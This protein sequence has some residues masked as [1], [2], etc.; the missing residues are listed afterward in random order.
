LPERNGAY[1]IEIK[2][3]GGELLRTINGNT[4]NS[5]IK[6]HWDLTDEHGRVCT[7]DSFDTV[8]HVTLPGSGR[9]QTLKG[10]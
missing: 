2:S 1:A 10:P 5:F 4:S 8:V 9:S 7:N 6:E 3:P